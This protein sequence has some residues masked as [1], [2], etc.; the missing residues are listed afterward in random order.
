MRNHTM[1]GRLLLSLSL[2][3]LVAACGKPAPEQ[4]APQWPGA[5]GNPDTAAA[6]KAAAIAA[7]PPVAG[8]P[9]VSAAMQAPGVSPE[10]PADRSTA[11]Q[12]AAATAAA[13]K[14]GLPVTAETRGSWACDNGETIDLRVF[15]DQGVAVL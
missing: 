10:Y 2:A 7:T 6:A 8:A 1:T 4:A 13:Q 15:P 11:E 9:P 12:R 14:A 5:L 3:A